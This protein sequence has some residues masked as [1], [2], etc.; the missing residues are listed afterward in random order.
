[1]QL[2]E[3]S[4]GRQALEGASVANGTQQILEALRDLDRRPPAPRDPLPEAILEREPEVMFSLE[5]AGLRRI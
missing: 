3:L 2:G 1:M 4:S 5:H